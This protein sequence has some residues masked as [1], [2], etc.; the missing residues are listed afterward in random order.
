MKNLYQNQIK[1]IVKGIYKEY[2]SCSN[3]SY[4]LI[5]NDIYL[6][7]YTNK[8]ET[9]GFI[10]EEILL[11]ELV[12]IR[13][14]K[15]Q[16]RNFKI[17]NDYNDSEITIQKSGKRYLISKDIM[18][19]HFTIKHNLIDWKSS[20]HYVYFYSKILDDQFPEAL[21][22]FYINSKVDKVT[23]IIKKVCVLLDKIKIPF[24][25]KCFKDSINYQRSD[26]IVLYVYKYDWSKYFSSLND[27]FITN[28]RNLNPNVPLFTYPIYHGIG[29][30]ENPNKINE[31][32]G[33]VR[34]KIISNAILQGF[35]NNFNQNECCKYVEKCIVLE[36]YDLNSF[37]LNPNSK[38]PYF[39]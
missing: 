25:L 38:Y 7:Y 35:E 11:R 18:L 27:F 36:G 23:E 17:I 14:N 1:S 4:S 22:R 13:V 12:R 39:K 10:D 34:S 6:N 28:E 2:N 32:F 19:N 8:C 3:I 30:G 26:N 16:M 15:I 33:S 9:D 37:Y 29:F 21:V 20:E 5:E 31:S 24:S